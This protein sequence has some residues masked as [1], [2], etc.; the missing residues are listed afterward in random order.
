MR[1][2]SSA[3]SNG[4]QRNSSAPALI[5][6]S[7]FARSTSAVTMTTGTKRVCG[8][9]FNRRQTSKPSPPGVRRSITTMSG[10]RV[11]QSSSAS[12]AVVTTDTVCPSRVSRRFR[13][14]A[15]I[16]SSSAIRID[17]SAS[18]HSSRVQDAVLSR[19][20]LVRARHTTCNSIQANYMEATLMR[21][22]KTICC[23][24]A[25]VAALASGARADEWNKRTFLTFSGPVQ[26]P[27]ATLPAGTYLFQLA[28]PDNARHVIM[29]RDKDE[30]K[31]YTMFMT[32]PNDRLDTPSDNVVMFRETPAGVARAVKAWWYPGNRMGEEFVYPKSQACA[33]AKATHERVLSSE[34]NASTTGSD[35]DRSA[36]NSAKIARVDETGAVADDEKQTPKP[37]TTG[38]TA[39]TTTKPGATTTGT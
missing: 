28:D 27:G 24:A 10:G 1:A 2:C 34:T 21:V 35:T 11:R 8:C 36:M 12:A 26:V 16:G 15:L 4:L 14:R 38:T 29:V 3:E 7:R 37:A 17:A 39:G 6:S 30:K 19:S 9:C 20:Y 18:M 33:I 31:V 5:P 22:M 13:Y 23:A 32:V 25:I